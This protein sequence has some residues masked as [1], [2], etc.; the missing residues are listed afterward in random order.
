MTGV[1]RPVPVRVGPRRAG[2]C[3]SLV[4]G[5]ARE[6]TELGWTPKFQD[7]RKMIAHA[8]A[9]D[10]SSFKSERRKYAV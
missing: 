9:W 10:P 6:A 3:A 2:D 5:S 4:S 7:L 8:A 1:T